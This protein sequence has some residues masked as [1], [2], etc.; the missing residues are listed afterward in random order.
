[1][2]LLCEVMQVSRSGYYH[3]CKAIPSERAREDIQLITE[4][5]ALAKISKNSYGNRQMT[6]NLQAKGYTVGRYKVRRLMKQAGIVCK[7]RKAFR[8]TTDSHHSL[9]VAKNVLNRE[10]RV[11]APNRVWVTDI[12]YLHTLEGWLYVAAVLDVFSRRI[13]GWAI[14]G[15][16]RESLVRDALMMA[17]QRR[18]PDAGLLHRNV[19]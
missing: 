15:H 7:Q 13:V 1:M 3:Y 9:P 6:K 16:M 17:L 19:L 2:T 10:F 8:V 4:L 12:T 5:K 11:S 18:Q 14:E